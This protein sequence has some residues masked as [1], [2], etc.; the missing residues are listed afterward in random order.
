MNLLTI[1]TI[2]IRFHQIKKLEQEEEGQKLK[3]THAKTGKEKEDNEV[4]VITKK[5][6]DNDIS[7][8]NAML[9]WHLW[10][11]QTNTIINICITDTDTK[12]YISKL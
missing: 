11:H 9:I 8:Y 1:R 4:C 3:T 7:L 12:L 6:K 5:D 10:K 2:I